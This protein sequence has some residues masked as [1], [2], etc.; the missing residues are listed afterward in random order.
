MYFDI[1]LEDFKKIKVYGKKHKIKL[2]NGQKIEVGVS[3]DG[4]KERE[5]VVTDIKS[6]LAINGNLDKKT[7][8][9]VAK[10][11]LNWAVEKY[12]SIDAFREKRLKELN[13]QCQ[14]KD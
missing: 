14:K 6:G 13:K 10:N 9:F 3:N 5:F 7:S 1:L 11:M 2:N 4:Y 8:L 12:G